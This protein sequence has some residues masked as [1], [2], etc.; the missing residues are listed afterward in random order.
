MFT[1]ADRVEVQGNSV[2][3]VSLD[4]I[5]NEAVALVDGDTYLLYGERNLHGG[6]TYRLY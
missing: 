3:I 2:E 4:P 6:Y 1:K 5:T